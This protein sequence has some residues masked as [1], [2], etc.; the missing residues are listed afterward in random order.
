MRRTRFP[1]LWASQSRN[2]TVARRHHWKHHTCFQNVSKRSWI[3]YD[4]KLI[5]QEDCA[6]FHPL[7]RIAARTLNIYMRGVG[8]WEHWQPPP[9]LIRLSEA[10]RTLVWTHPL[11][12]QRL[13]CQT[14]LS[15]AFS[16][17]CSLSVTVTADASILSWKEQRAHSD[18]SSS[19]ISWK[20]RRRQWQYRRVERGGRDGGRERRQKPCRGA[21][22]KVGRW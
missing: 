18:G 13:R 20:L 4:Y 11:L 12:A 3:N 15:P 7:L 16:C 9:G 22:G 6:K 10:P 14:A 8:V 17:L 21:S 19:T 2:Y 5:P 1:S